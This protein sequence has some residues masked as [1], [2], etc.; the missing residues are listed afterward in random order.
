MEVIS[1]FD[2]PGI[3]N[4]MLPPKINERGDAVRE[5][6]DPADQRAPL[7]GSATLVIVIQSLIL[8]SRLDL[9][10]IRPAVIQSQQ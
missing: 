9:R 5:F 3:G 4:S 6:I 10:L 7:S 8:T 1:T 2:H